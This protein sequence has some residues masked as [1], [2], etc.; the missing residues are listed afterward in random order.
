[1]AAIKSVLSV[2]VTPEDLVSIDNIAKL[3]NKDRSDVA[4][5]LIKI[6]MGNRLIEVVYEKV[7]K[8]EISICSSAS[9][10]KMSL[11]EFL[12]SLLEKNIAVPYSLE[13]LEEDFEGVL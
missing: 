5:E 3:E 1:M 6:G 7:R 4:R 9:M 13:D 11:H 10:A 8:K 2:R 12:E